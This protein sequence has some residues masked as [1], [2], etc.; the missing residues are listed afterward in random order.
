MERGIIMNFNPQDYVI[1][2]GITGSRLY[3][4]NIESSNT[5]Y[6]SVCLPPC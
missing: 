5:D 3:G 2:E 6:R 4:I 1:F